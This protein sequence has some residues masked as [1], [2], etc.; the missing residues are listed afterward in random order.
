MLADEAR[1]TPA[2]RRILFLAWAGWLFDFYDLI[3]YSFLLTDIRGSW[4]FPSG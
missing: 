4:G 1:L 2:H 3:L